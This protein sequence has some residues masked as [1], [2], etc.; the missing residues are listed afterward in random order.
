MEMSRLTG[1]YP[2]PVTSAFTESSLVITLSVWHNFRYN[3]CPQMILIQSEL[4]GETAH[5]VSISLLLPPTYKGWKTTWSRSRKF[6]HSS[7]RFSVRRTQL[8]FNQLKDQLVWQPFTLQFMWDSC[9][10]FSWSHMVSEI[11]MRTT[12]LSTSGRASEVAFQRAWTIKIYSTGQNTP[13]SVICL[14]NIQVFPSICIL[15]ILDQG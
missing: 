10:C 9:G 2:T 1:L 5:V 15:Y 7:G 14:G 6:S 11:Q 13:C 4:P 8:L 12:S 3:V